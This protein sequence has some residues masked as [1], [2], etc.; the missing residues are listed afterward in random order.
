MNIILGLAASIM[1]AACGDTAP[2]NVVATS[3]SGD[4]AAVLQDGHAWTLDAEKSTL[5]FSATQQNEQFTGRFKNFT[6]Q[7][8]LN[9]D[10]LSNAS[11]KAVIEMK[12]VDAGAADRNG[13]LPTRVWFNVKTFPEAS[14]T[15]S[16]VTHL[17]GDDYEATGTLSIKGVSKEVTLPFTLTIVADVAT[18]S[19]KLSLNRTDFNVGEGDYADGS[20]IGFG[21]EVMVDLV[22]TR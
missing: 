5:R 2:S 4:Q 22:A 13:S 21:V 12:S 11:I 19:G 17:Q 8:N 16:S 9:P 6:A 18:A 1:L 3:V 10:D 20:E 7:I 15:S 14:F